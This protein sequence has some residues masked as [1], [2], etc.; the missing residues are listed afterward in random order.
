MFRTWYQ[1]K[2]RD[3]AKSCWFGAIALIPAS[4]IA[5]TITWWAIFVAMLMGPGLLFKLSWTAVSIM[6]WVILVVLFAWQFTR[7]RRHKEEYKFSGRPFTNTEWAAIRLSGETWLTF[8]FDPSAGSAFVTFLAAWFLTAPKLAA[9]SLVLHSR[10][11]CLNADDVEAYVPVLR[12]LMRAKSGIPLEE[13]V[14]RHK[15]AD[16]VEML[17]TLT[18]ID[19]VVAL[20][21]DDLSLTIAPRLAQEYQDWIRDNS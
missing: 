16:P 11:T 15:I 17:R 12:E 3:A 13:L 2:T 1:T 14:E 21:Q 5:A 9:L 7:G 18:A 6:T 8:V 4:L 10:A 20:T 19:G